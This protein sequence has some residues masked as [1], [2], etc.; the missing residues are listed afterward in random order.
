MDNK[1]ILKMIEAHAE[2][3]EEIE[4]TLEALVQLLFDLIEG[5]GFSAEDLDR[6]KSRIRNANAK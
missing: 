3:L 6:L 5:M 4:S 1:E 2:R